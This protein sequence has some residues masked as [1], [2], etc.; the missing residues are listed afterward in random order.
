MTGTISAIA[1]KIDRV[2][3]V[4][5]L[6]FLAI[7]GAIIIAVMLIIFGYVD[8]VVEI[9]ALWSGIITAIIALLKQPSNGTTQ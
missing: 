5:M 1:S 6:A 4:T 9:L 7:V 2:E 8:Y 3:A